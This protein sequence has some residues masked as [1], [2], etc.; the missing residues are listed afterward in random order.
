[1][2]YIINKDSLLKV[3]EGDSDPINMEPIKIGKTKYDR[4][5]RNADERAFEFTNTG[6]TLL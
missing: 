3:F 5:F 4:H 6:D 1:M 2:K